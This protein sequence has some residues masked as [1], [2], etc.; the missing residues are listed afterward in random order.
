MK[1]SVLVTFCNQKAYIKDALD[2][3]VNQKTNFD[4][5]ILVGLD[6]N[7]ADSETIINTYLEKYKNIKLFKCDNSKLKTINIEKASNN[8]INLIKHAQG[9]YFCLLDGDDF[10]I[11]DSRFQKLINILDKNQEIIGCGH[12]ISFF[13]NKNKTFKLKNFLNKNRTINA[14]EYIDNKMHISSN[15]FIFRNIFDKSL[16]SDFPS[17][18]F[19]D[20]TITSYM[21]KYG[22]LFYITDSMLAYR[23][24]IDSIFMAEEYKSRKFQQLL[25]SE[26]NH[27]VLSAYTKNL[28]IRYKFLLVKCLKFLNIKTTPNIDLIK[29]FAKENNCYFTYYILNFNNLSAKEKIDFLLKII[30]Y[31]F[32]NRY[33][34]Q[35]KSAELLYF[36]GL[37]NFGDVL[38]LYVL[39][40]L[41][42][43]NVK[44]QH[45]TKANLS[46]IGSVLEGFLFK[47]IQLPVILNKKI[48]NIWGSGFIEDVNLKRHPSQKFSRNVNILA[49]RGYLSKQRCENILNKN[50]DNIAL[51]DPGLLVSKLIDVSAIKKE[52]KVGI[53]LHYVDKNSDLIKNIELKDYYLINIEWN[54]IKTIKEIAKCE[55]IFSSAMHG[56]IA[57]DSLGIPNQWIQLSDNVYGENYKFKDYYS[58]FGIETHLPVDL[59]TDKITDKTVEKV[60]EEYSQKISMQT[61]EQ[62]QASLL[63]SFKNYRES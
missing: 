15:A 47:K 51:G 53:I 12:S 32:L 24:N 1:L 16:P 30:K 4:Y 2:S 19:N 59:R 35:Y 49:L 63:N 5:E 26:I 21:L 27:K 45:R 57:A 39:Q 31:I 48:L 25:A 20:S 28:C 60:L 34:I 36:D 46:A 7:D 52:H 55:V 40:R 13:D 43:V 23:T 62:I 22:K 50:L 41:L 3:I 17:R 11:D 6:G 54:P 10:Y 8:R 58:V 37:N 56:L 61:I 42:G 29:N 18:F 14:R 9:E 33:P 44:K 38:N